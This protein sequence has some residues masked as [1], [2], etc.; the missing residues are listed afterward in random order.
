M[1]TI[2]EFVGRTLRNI[3]L[4]RAAILRNITVKDGVIGPESPGPFGTIPYS[5]RELELLRSIESDLQSLLMIFDRQAET[6][7][8][9]KDSTW[10]DGT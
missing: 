6:I 3:K 7:G 8:L 5:L 4:R 1:I 2:E 9:P 10:T